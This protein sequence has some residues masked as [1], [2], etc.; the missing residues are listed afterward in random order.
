MYNFFLAIL[1]LF[2][3]L[4]FLRPSADPLCSEATRLYNMEDSW[5][6]SRFQNLLRESRSDQ[7][8]QKFETLL[9]IFVIL[10]DQSQSKSFEA[11]AGDSRDCFG[12]IPTKK[13]KATFRLPDRAC[14]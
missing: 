3:L 13:W 8:F 11:F 1:F 12:H 9:I 7:W 14:Q 6:V 4:F 10:Y 2:A 5:N